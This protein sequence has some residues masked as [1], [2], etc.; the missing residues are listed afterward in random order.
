MEPAARYGE[1]AA[2]EAIQLIPE[3][4]TTLKQKSMHLQELNVSG[5]I[6]QY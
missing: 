2:E 5:A 1:T 6:T 4:L 3:A